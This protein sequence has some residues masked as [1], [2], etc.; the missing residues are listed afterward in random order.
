M[1]GKDGRGK[2][3]DRTRRLGS[4]PSPG[5]AHGRLGRGRAV[6][7]HGSRFGEVRLRGTT[8]HLAFLTPRDPGLLTRPLVRPLVDRQG[9]EDLGGDQL[10]RLGDV[11]HV[12]RRARGG[13]PRHVPLPAN[14]RAA[15]H[16]EEAASCALLGGRSRF[17]GAPIHGAHLSGELL[18]GHAP[19]V[20]DPGRLVLVPGQTRQEAHLR[21]A[22]RARDQ[23]VFQPGKGAQAQ[24][25]L[26]QAPNGAGREPQPL[27]GVVG[28]PRVADALP[29]AERDQA[30]GDPGQDRPKRTPLAAQGLKPSVQLP[31]DLVPADVTD[32]REAQPLVRPDQA[33]V[34]SRLQWGFEDRLHGARH[35]RFPFETP[36][37]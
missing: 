5:R 12:A 33:R 23:G 10:G 6:P 3:G 15:G 7:A 14:L 20:G 34:Q 28:E 21:P 9:R 22:Q 4:V 24:P 29:S 11:E 16:L 30:G 18:R 32:L 13:P 37:S 26:G 17:H 1:E 8:C 19:G 36:G 31:G 2:L 35:A 25:N 27:H